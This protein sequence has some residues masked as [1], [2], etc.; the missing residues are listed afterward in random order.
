MIGNPQLRSTQ[1]G[2]L[3]TESRSARDSNG[4]RQWSFHNPVRITFG[5]GSLD[6]ISSVLDGRRYV[7]VTYG[8]SRF[9][10]M[11]IQI[12]AETGEPLVV[13]DDV[14]P[15][16]D[17]IGL[18][19]SCARFGALPEDPEVIVALGGGSVIDTA[20]VLSASAG[21]FERVRRY[22][23]DHEGERALGSVPIIAIP[24][25]AGTGSEVTSWA[26]VWDPIAGRKY[27]LSRPN[28]YPEHALV[29]PELT[30]GIPRTLTVSTAL[31]A[32]S[33]SL[34]SIWNVNANPV[35]TNFAV[36]AATEILDVLPSL[37]TDLGS[38]P[39]RSRMARAALLAGLAF[40]N[41]RTALAHS[42]SYPI[43]LRYGLPH[44]IACS[45]SL[46]MLLRAVIGHDMEC[47][48]GL[49][50]IFGGDLLAG[51]AR[52]TNFLT[53]LDVSASAED[54][55]VPR[56]AFRDLI[57]T[58]YVGERGRNFIGS[59][60]RV[61]AAEEQQWAAR[62]QFEIDTGRSDRDDATSQ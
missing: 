9:R 18:A 24:T 52:L 12:A 26:S 51:V 27:S 8:E 23:V 37:V 30:L 48:E 7:L 32:L 62:N 15:N 42:L 35:S 17:F 47:D 11:A 58:A 36:V 21:D 55:G 53:D 2:L 43:T 54:H 56:E 38:F 22:L 59:K 6:R 1:D 14:S 45:F 41:T 57:A 34:E 20:K 19:R 44:G 39:L 31:D 61:L 46:P 4:R 25:T 50:R 13:I 60:D 10:E 3:G 5:G 49:K 29:D 28:L 16:P 33:H 40:S